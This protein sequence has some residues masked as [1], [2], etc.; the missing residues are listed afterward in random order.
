[1]CRYG[2]AAVRRLV[3]RPAEEPGAPEGALRTA[4]IKRH[5]TMRLSESGR[6]NPI[7]EWAVNRLIRLV[8]RQLS[9]SQS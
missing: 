7:T 4:A 5:R 9:G 6:L 8:D 2:G 3:D 1:M